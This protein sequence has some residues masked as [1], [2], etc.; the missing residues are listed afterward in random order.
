MILLVGQEIGMEGTSGL[1]W[2]VGREDQQDYG[3]EECCYG[4]L[5]Q[6]QECRVTIGEFCRKLKLKAN[7]FRQLD[8]LFIS[9]NVRD[10]LTHS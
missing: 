2:S 7:N 4:K 5:I 6:S 10:I 1:R 8:A 3:K 9:S